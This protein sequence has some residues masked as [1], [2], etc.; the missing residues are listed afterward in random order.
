VA[1]AARIFQRLARQFGECSL[2]GRIGPLAEGAIEGVHAELGGEARGRFRHAAVA[3]RVRHGSGK[4]DV[5]EDG[6]FPRFAVAGD[7][8]EDPGCELAAIVREDGRECV[9]GRA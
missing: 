7:E 9:E 2:A 5:L 1:A 6:A 4:P 3:E 8:R